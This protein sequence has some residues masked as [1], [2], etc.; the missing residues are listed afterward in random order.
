MSVSQAHTLSPSA[1]LARVLGR[2]GGRFGLIVDLAFA[3]WLI[4]IFDAINNLG[5]VRQRL[6]EHNGRNVLSVEHAL[7]LAPERALDSWLSARSTLSQI[8]VFWYENVH[9]IVTL[10][11]L[12]LLWWRR[13]EI[14]RSSELT[15]VIANLLALAVFW[16]FPVAPP[17]M[18]P[19]YVDLVAVTRHL[20][21]WRVGAVALHANQLCSMPSL[22]IAWASWSSI[23]VWRLTGRL[24][25]RVLAVIYPFITTFAVMAT[26]NHYL[27]D[28]VV[29]AAITFAVV[30]L[31]RSSTAWRAAR[32]APL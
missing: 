5:S 13:P 1:A 26:G 30:F 11:M 6:A 29:G 19:G 27:A 16:T 28:A 18:L 7:H 17:R 9:I 8:V 21:P 4:W 14:L 12:A 15:L 31:Q 10:V 25:L 22:H 2:R 32:T 3:S 23:A 24:W 20:P